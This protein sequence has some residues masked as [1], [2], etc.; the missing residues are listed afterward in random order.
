M[1]HL[2]FVYAKC[3][4]ANGFTRVGYFC[5]LMSA[6][7][8][9]WYPHSYKIVP[10]HGVVA[11]I[12]WLLAGLLLCGLASFGKGTVIGYYLAY[13]RLLRKRPQ[14][15]GLTVHPSHGYCFRQGVALAVRDYERQQKKI[16]K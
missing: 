11:I 12:A 2:L 14:G 9:W 7:F 13:R 10:P 4:W 3:V 6:Y 15:L 16:K 1:F 5:L 8:W